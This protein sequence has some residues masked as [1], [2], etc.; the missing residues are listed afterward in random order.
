[1]KTIILENID[2]QIWNIEYKL[3]EIIKPL[4]NG[5][6]VTISLNSE[7]PCAESLGLFSLLDKICEEFNCNCEN[8]TIK[9]VNQVEKSDKYRIIKSPNHFIKNAQDLMKNC[10]VL[11]KDFDSNFKHFGTFIGRQ[12]W[13]RLWIASTLYKNHKDKTCMTYLFSQTEDHHLKNTDLNNFFDFLGFS[14]LE[15]A[16]Q[17]LKQTPYKSKKE[18]SKWPVPNPEHYD[19][20]DQ[21]SNFFVDI[22]CETYFTGNTFF[23]NEKTWR[24][25]IAKT[26]FIIQGPANFLKNLKKLGFKTFDNWW[27]ELYQDFDKLP[28]DCEVVWSTK[29]IIQLINE[30]SEKSISELK[31][32]YNDMKPVLDF[33]YNR[34]QEID[35]KN[36]KLE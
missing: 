21:Y 24:P 8:I 5:E 11:G 35:L 4:L 3:I 18:I 30:L 22:V 32:M 14:E 26:P 13:Q 36:L 20:L 6:T 7:G 27:S 28:K 23:P 10:N 25:I 2:C 12:N 16:V 1:M 29:E 15:D 33:N 17:F 9:T 34:L 19:V 31:S